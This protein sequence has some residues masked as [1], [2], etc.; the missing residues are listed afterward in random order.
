MNRVI[1]C[2]HGIGKKQLDC[3]VS[4]SLFQRQINHIK[5]SNYRITSVE[6]LIQGIAPINS[7]AIT[8]DDGLKSSLKAIRWLLERDIPVLWSVL[9]FPESSL[10]QKLTDRV[11]NLRTISKMLCDYPKL[12]IA[13]HSSTHRDLT[14]I[15][16]KEAYR[17]VSESHDRLQNELQIPV[18]YFVYPFGKTNVKISRFLKT[19]G[20]KAAFTTTALP[21]KLNSDCYMLPRLCINEKLYPEE[22]LSH[23]LGLGG[24]TYLHLANCYRNFFPKNHS[25]V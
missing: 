11:V 18:R 7:L 25:V 22:R 20:Y 13:S 5:K 3:N 24:G 19:V 1:L 6:S 15:T 8:F 10:H 12:E 21:L 9:A 16:L 4:W 17:E 14:I 23:L 2:Y